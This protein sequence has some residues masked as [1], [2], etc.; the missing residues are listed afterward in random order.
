[1]A[2][3][4][5]GTAA[6]ETVDFSNFTEAHDVDLLGGAD[7]AIL[8][9]LDD[10]YVLDLNDLAVD[11][12]AGT[13]VIKDNAGGNLD[14]TDLGAYVDFE[15]IS[16]ENASITDDVDA[17]FINVWGGIHFGIDATHVNTFDGTAAGG[18]MVIDGDAGDTVH[19]ELDPLDPAGFSL[20]MA[21]VAIPGATS[22]SGVYDIYTSGGGEAVLVESELTVVDGI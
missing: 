14:I 11:G 4:Y 5:T 2:I 18:V 8:S 17:G 9:G 20:S 22:S 12:G 1:M 21:G 7:T 3:S 6:A 15:V 19:L 16:T 10:S 13:D